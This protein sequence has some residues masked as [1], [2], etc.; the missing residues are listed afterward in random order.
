MIWY[1]ERRRVDQFD[2]WLKR[3][4]W[5]TRENKWWGENKI[6]WRFGLMTFTESKTIIWNQV[7]SYRTMLWYK[8]QKETIEVVGKWFTQTSVNWILY[9]IFFFWFPVPNEAQKLI[10]ELTA[11]VPEK[12]A[13]WW[14]G[15]K[16]YLRCR[17]S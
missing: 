2:G 11:L 12:L 8:Q 9:I 6:G 14:M 16:L 15:N 4:F 7:L 1:W 3:Q 10:T 17:F 5:S 13:H